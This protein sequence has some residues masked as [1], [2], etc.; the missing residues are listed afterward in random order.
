MPRTTEQPV[1]V[2]GE[3][4][5][6]HIGHRQLVHQAGVLAQRLR[7]PLVATILVAELPDGML[8]TVEER[9]W[10]LLA[11]GASQV[12]AMS[13]TTTGEA[14]AGSSVADELIARLDPA[15]VVMACLPFDAPSAR[16]PSLRAGF[17][18][19]AVEMVE[20]PRWNDPDGQYVTSARIRDALRRGDIVAANDW[21][22]RTFTL[23]GTGVHG[24]ALGRT[25]GFATAHLDLPPH[26]VVPMNGVYAGIVGLPNGARHRAAIN[27]G[28]RPTVET[29][30]AVL[31]EAHLLDF[32]DD[33]Y[34][35]TIDVS[36][37]RWLRH[38]QRFDSLDALVAQLALDVDR[39]RLLLRGS[40][41]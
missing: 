33:L 12:Q 34:G 1:V 6:F 8:T 25:I 11:S 27:I 15:C 22:G 28:V 38:E 3:F 40:I 26:R 4:D 18:R 7:R 20:M 13:V 32:D 14:D 24:S 10:A 29:D 30:G 39:T 35:A 19:H 37:T 2:V 41:E 17:A 36:F 21:M 23:T 16:H 9:C 31:V 5:G